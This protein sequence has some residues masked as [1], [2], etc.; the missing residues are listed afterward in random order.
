MKLNG[1]LKSALLPLYGEL[2]K[3]NPA[4]N[5]PE[6]LCAF[7]AQWGSE[8]PEKEKE[9]ILFVGKATNGWLSDS[10][11]INVLFGDSCGRIFDRD[12]QMR[13]VDTLE[14]NRRE[15]NTRKSAFWRV[16]KG[17]S[18]RLYPEDWYAHVAWSNL[19]KLSPY[20]KKGNPDSRLRGE[21]LAVCKKILEKEIEILSPKHVVMFTYDW[22]CC[23]LKYLNDGKAPECVATEVWD[24][25]KTCVYRIG[26]TIY[27]VSPH[28]QG[29]EEKGHIAVIDKLLNTDY[30]R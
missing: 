28:P 2:L 24:R 6:D 4:G 20:I 12:D 14:G 29:K 16:I 7:C 19:Y 26:D 15:Y 25:Y 3:R 30:R 5:S 9:G 18:R 10:T 23:F 22:E 21:Q 17:V 13:W 27:I 1:K 11:D 8:F